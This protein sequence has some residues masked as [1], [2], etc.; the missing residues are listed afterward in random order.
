MA[1]ILCGCTSDYCEYANQGEQGQKKT[2][3]GVLKFQVYNMKPANV[4]NLVRV[5]GPPSSNL[6]LKFNSKP[7]LRQGPGDNL[8]QH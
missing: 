8:G 7:Y 1:E 5:Y 6:R 3:K 4:F 2:E